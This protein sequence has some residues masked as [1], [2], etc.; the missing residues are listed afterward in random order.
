MQL[1]MLNDPASLRASQE[2]VHHSPGLLKVSMAG[3]P[4]VPEVSCQ[5]SASTRPDMGPGRQVSWWLDTSTTSQ[6]RVLMRTA[7]CSGWVT[8]K[9]TE[10]SGVVRVSGLPPSR[11]PGTQHKNT[12]SCARKVT[13]ESTIPDKTVS[14]MDGIEV[15]KGQADKN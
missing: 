3:K 7:F 10:E 5:Y 2:P 8:L 13:L 6:G 12:N 9:P 1:I 14:Q 15:R 11:E 4:L